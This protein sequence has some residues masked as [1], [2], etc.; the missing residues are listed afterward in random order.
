MTRTALITIAGAFAA[1]AVLTATATGAHSQAWTMTLDAQQSETHFIDNAPKGE[2]PGDVI[3]FTD[4][5]RRHGTVVGFAEISGTLIDKKRDAD[6]LQGTIK[7]ASGQIMISGISL[8]QTPVQTFAIVGGTGHY[9]GA[10]G[11]ATIKTGGH[12]ATILLRTSL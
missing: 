7:L 8:G 6:E 2:S 1:C 11:T 4:T 3:A 9:E 5:L 12:G 10:R